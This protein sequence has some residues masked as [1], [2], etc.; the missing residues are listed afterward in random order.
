MATGLWVPQTVDF[1][2]S[3][4]VEGYESISTDPDDY[5]DQAVLILGKGNSAF[6][7]AQ[8]ILGRASRVHM[9]SSS[10]V[11]LAWQTH[12]V[13]DLRSEL[14]DTS[15]APG[16]V[17]ELTVFLLFRAVN[18]ELLDTY[19][20]KSLDGLVEAR[21]EKIVIARRREQHEGKRTEARGKLYLTL[22]KY[23]QNGSD[24]SGEELA[25][26]HIDN[27]PT[28]KPYDRVIRCLGFRFNFSI[29]DR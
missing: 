6:E 18:N 12:Y 14:S 23:V 1:V 28:R 22:T 8:S 17:G 5:Q 7:T 26:H 10:A 21:L 4:L 24:V 25:G 13:G 3:D 16:P 29:F 20:L 9:L 19:Q 15:P 2:G 27:F 11:R